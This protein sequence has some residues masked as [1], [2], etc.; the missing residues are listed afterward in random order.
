MLGLLYTNYIYNEL[1][2]AININYKRVINSET[3]QTCLPWD[4]VT[5]TYYTQRFWHFVRLDFCG[6]VLILFCVDYVKQGLGRIMRG[7]VLLSTTAVPVLPSQD[8]K[9]NF[10]PLSL[11]LPDKT[12]TVTENK[13][14]LV[15]TSCCSLL[16]VHFISF[17]KVQYVILTAD[18]WTGYCSSNSQQMLTRVARLMRKAGIKM[19]NNGH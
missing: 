19:I 13:F 8:Q 6:S 12:H 1:P 15:N 5:L 18:G 17:L 14:S 2:L 9:K 7:D 10:L 4:L 11:V 16:P 3:H